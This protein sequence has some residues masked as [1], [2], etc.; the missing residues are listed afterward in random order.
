MKIGLTFTT[1]QFTMYQQ[2]LHKLLT[3]ATLLI[4]LDDFFLPVTPPPLPSQQ[5]CAST[6]IPTLFIRQMLSKL[7]QLKL[8]YL[9]SEQ[10]FSRYLIAYA[11][12][13]F[14]SDPNRFLYPADSSQSSTG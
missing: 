6:H 8:K 12:L 1:L 13:F 2:Q 3:T 14:L 7:A 9:S 10:N 5:K 4:H 11:M